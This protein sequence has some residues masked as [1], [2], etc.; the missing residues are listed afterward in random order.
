MMP[1]TF[2]E[3]SESKQ[4]HSEYDIGINL[5]ILLNLLMTCVD[6]VLRHWYCYTRGYR[7]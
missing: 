6:S 3:I 7:F 4:N 2:I 1:I 5:K